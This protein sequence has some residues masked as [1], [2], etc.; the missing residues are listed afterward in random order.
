MAGHSGRHTT[1]L[2]ELVEIWH[3]LSGREINSHAVLL[4]VP[5]R[6]GRTHLL[7]QFAAVIEEDEA[8]SIVVHIPGAALPEGLGLQALELRKL[9][10]E[11]RV[12]HRVAELLGVDR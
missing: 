9:F 6:W 12:K 3:E 7:N 10:S 4:P 1:V 8:L 11:A 5:P 2:D